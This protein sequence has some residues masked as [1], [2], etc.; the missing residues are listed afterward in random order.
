V[1]EYPNY[2]DPQ[3]TFE[4]RGL[5]EETSNFSG[6]HRD[7]FR[8][9]STFAQDY[10]L[11]EVLVLLCSF[12][13]EGVLNLSCQL[14]LCQSWGDLQRTSRTSERLN[15]IGFSDEL[16]YTESERK[17]PTVFTRNLIT[18]CLEHK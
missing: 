6:I 12:S 17:G 3:M 13:T 11:L 14:S 18:F 15:C 7:G 4:A 2:S 9:R 8:T 10:I 16:Y 1:L 5:Q